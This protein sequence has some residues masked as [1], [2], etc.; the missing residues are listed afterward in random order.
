MCAMLSISKTQPTRRVSIMQG[1]VKDYD[2]HGTAC[3]GIIAAIAND[4]TQHLFTI[5]SL[6]P[7]FLDTWNLLL[8]CSCF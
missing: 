3:A 7:D 5:I 4:L 6:I 8:H 1:G 2:G